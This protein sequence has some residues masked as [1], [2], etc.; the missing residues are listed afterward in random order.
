MATREQ[1]IDYLEAVAYGRRR[2]PLA[3]IIGLM[4][5]LLSGLYRAALWVYLRPFEIGLRKQRRLGRPVVSIGNITVGGTG[6]TPTV[7]YICRELG[8]CGWS[9]VVLSYG[10]RGALHGEFGIVSSR[11]GIL[12]S[13]DIAGDEPAM[14]ANSL[15]GVPVLVGKDRVKSGLAAI[16]E[17]KA[18]VLVIDDGF[19]IRKLHRDLDIV[20][21][22]IVNPFDNARTLPAGRL[23]EPLSALR[24]ADCIIATGDCEPALRE[25]TL[26]EIRRVAPGI[27]VYSGLFCPRSIVS[28]ADLSEY[29]VEW[30]RGRSVLSLSAIANPASFESMLAAN[31]AALVAIQRVEDHHS[32]T[33][34]DMERISRMARES[35]AGCVVTTEKDAIKL[36]GA[37]LDVP[38]FMLRIGLDLNDED[39]FR[40]F[41]ASRIGNAPL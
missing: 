21:L 30:V 25:S 12:L 38:V 39:G 15:P 29:P 4:L 41:M 24:R 19:Q 34:G 22:S 8:G 40:S 36:R 14:L 31:G 7:Q 13:S 26:A 20:L 5:L 28:L 10:Y 2:D 1:V 6:K 9:P 32:Y 37:K 17:M 18:D 11:S 27:P 23:R 3:L 33:N 16:N 35:G